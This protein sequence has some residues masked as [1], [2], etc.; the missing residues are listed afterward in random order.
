[1]VVFYHLVTF[2]MQ[3]YIEQRYAIKFCVKLNKCATE[4]FVSLAEARTQ[5]TLAVGISDLELCR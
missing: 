4:T 3:E 2:A 1:M 5:L